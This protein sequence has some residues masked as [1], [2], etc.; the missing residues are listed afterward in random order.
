[1]QETAAQYKLRV[2]GYLDGRPPLALQASVPKKIERLVKAAP[3][4]RLKRRPAPGKWSVAEI[5]AHLADDE[6]VIGYRY[7]AVAG[8][9]GA[10][11]QGFDQD[12]WAESMAYHRRP[13]LTSL[14]N[15]LAL[16][17]INL[18]LLKSLTPAQWQLHGLHSERGPETIEELA[19]L[20]AGHDLNHLRQIEAILNP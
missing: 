9:P 13:P 20:T 10:A 4:G 1:M 5:L 3:P 18:V 6:L 19:R 11:I 16:R 15:F 7:R 2:L 17:Q 8:Q 14:R 12:R